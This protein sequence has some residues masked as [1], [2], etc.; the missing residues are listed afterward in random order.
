MSHTPDAPSG[1][2]GDPATT[3]VR[4]APG[5]SIL[6]GWPGAD[7]DVDPERA[8]VW[9]TSDGG[10]NAAVAE[11]Q[12]SDRAMPARVDVVALDDAVRC[13]TAAGP[14]DGVSTTSVPFQPS[15]VTVHVLPQRAGLGELGELLVDC[16]E[17]I[18]GADHP[19]TVV[20][21]DLTPLVHAH[22]LRD[23]FTFLHLLTTKV[24][25]MGARA[26]VGATDDLDGSAFSTLCPLFDEVVDRRH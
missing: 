25:A 13:A 8:V 14:D 1:P 2:D 6:D 19:V 4:R 20:V 12:R 7:D 15:D 22:G 11:L 3:L 18:G 5:Q 23:V 10:P 26:L 21:E 9:A 16:F 24:D 17:R